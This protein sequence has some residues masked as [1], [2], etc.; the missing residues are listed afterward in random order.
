MKKRFRTQF[1]ARHVGIS[2]HGVK[3]LADPQYKNDCSIEGII[4]R[5]GI[6]PRPDYIPVDADISDI[7]DFASCLERV[8]DGLEHFKTLPSD[9]RSR[10]G[11]DPKAFFAWISDPANTT[12]AVRVGLMVERKHEPTT[13]ERLDRIADGINKIV[14]SKEGIS[15]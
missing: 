1:E 15:A 8:Q 2:F 9:V 11:N 7:G 14:T 10:F 4:K 3:S 13:G 12:E 5:Y 6:L